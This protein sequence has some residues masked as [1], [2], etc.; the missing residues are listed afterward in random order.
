LNMVVSLWDLEV[1]GR[2]AGLVDHGG[3]PRCRALNPL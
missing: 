1:A 2:M 3:D